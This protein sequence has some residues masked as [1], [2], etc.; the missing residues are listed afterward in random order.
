MIPARYMSGPK[1]PGRGMSASGRGELVSSV[2]PAMVCARADRSG[3]PIDISTNVRGALWA[4]ANHQLRET[5]RY[6]RLHNC[7]TAGLVK[8]EGV[9]V[10]LRDLVDECVAVRSRWRDAPG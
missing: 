3:V 9:T 6:L 2:E 7:P 10:V 5:R 1:W 4:E 8:G